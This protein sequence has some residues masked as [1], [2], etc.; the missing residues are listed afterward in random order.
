MRIQN[1]VQSPNFGALVKTPEGKLAIRRCKDVQLLA[2]LV[3]ADKDMAGTE[4]FDIVVGKDLKCKITSL[5]EAFFGVFKN[6]EFSNVR[7]GVNEDILELGEYSVSRHPIYQNDEE[8]GYSVWKTEELGDVENAE[9]IDTLVKIA[10]TL[11]NEAVKHEKR[12][13]SEDINIGIAKKLQ[14]A[15]L[16]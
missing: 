3:Q 15:L 5:K 13:L 9:N 12:S 16:G 10:K 2:K 1:N 11:D 4:F 6:R 8:Y 7:N 14:H